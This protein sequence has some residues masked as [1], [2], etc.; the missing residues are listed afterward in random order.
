MEGQPPMDPR[1]EGVISSRGSKIL[2]RH[3]ILENN[4]NKPVTNSSDTQE[5]LQMLTI[6]KSHEAGTTILED[7]DFYEQRE[8]ALQEN[9]RQQQAAST[10]PRK[11]V[12]TKLKRTRAR[13]SAS[14]CTSIC[15]GSRTVRGATS[16]TRCALAS[17]SGWRRRPDSGGLG[18]GETQLHKDEEVAP[19]EASASTAP[20]LY[21]RELLWVKNYNPY[22]SIITLVWIGSVESGGSTWTPLS[23]P[24]IDPPHAHIGLETTEQEPIPNSPLRPSPP[25]R[26]E[27]RARW[28]KSRERPPSNR[29]P[30]HH[31]L[32]LRL[33]PPA[34]PSPSL[35]RQQ[36]SRPRHG[37]VRAARAPAASGGARG[38]E[39]QGAPQRG[40]G[41][42]GARDA[43]A[44]GRAGQ[45]VEDAAVWCAVHGLVVGDRANQR[46]GMVPGVGLVHAPFS[47][48]PAR[49]PASFFNQACELA[50]IFNELV[51]R[52][53]L[54]GEFL[55]A[56]LSRKVNSGLSFSN[57]RTK[58]VDEFTLRLLEIHDKMMSINKKEV[59][60]NDI[61]PES[62]DAMRPVQ[63]HLPTRTSTPASKMNNL[64]K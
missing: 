22:P 17:R 14:T 9:R 60:Q 2:M 4:D 8:K 57:F 30:P 48:L 12:D 44:A 13:R 41:G 42:G 20:D 54:D 58:Q 31:V 5:G 50:P 49:F 29:F 39:R 47:L 33:A 59:V 43:G 27:A 63:Q 15:C 52:V 10:D 61:P 24:E 3:I 51:D 45:M 11:L 36:P 21:V 18:H 7:F 55:Q 19:T 34:G 16:R 23:R 35:R 37:L 40:T 25:P 56:A 28:H 26:H 53:S 62:M 6:F 32:P 38:D 64:P 1:L 46:S